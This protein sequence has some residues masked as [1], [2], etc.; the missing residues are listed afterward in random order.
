M[1]L[2]IF[3]R[4]ICIIFNSS[5]CMFATPCMGVKIVH[6]HMRIYYFSSCFKEWCRG[7]PFLLHGRITIPLPR[8]VS[9]VSRSAVGIL[10]F[11]VKSVTLAFV[12]VIRDATPAMILLVL[13]CK[14]S[15]LVRVAIGLTSVMLLPLK[16]KEGRLMRGA[17]GL[18][19]LMLPLKLK[20]IR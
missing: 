16:Y 1:R 5:C 9:N 7:V 3:H 13:K 15:R 18:K 8:A 10:E 11:P 12:K 17:S 19:S 6:M 4:S 2:Q 20:E 14:L